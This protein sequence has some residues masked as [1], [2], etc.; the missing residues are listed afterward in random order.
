MNSLQEEVTQLFYRLEKKFSGRDFNDL[1]LYC[2]STLYN[3]DIARA[4]AIVTR[5]SQL[6]WNALKAKGEDDLRRNRHAP[7]YCIDDCLYRYNLPF[8]KAHQDGLHNIAN[9][10]EGRPHILKELDQ[11]NYREY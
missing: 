7:I 11:L 8:D 1:L 5:R 3:N 2:V 6:L 4:Q 9:L 10:L